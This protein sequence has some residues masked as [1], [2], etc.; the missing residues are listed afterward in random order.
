MSVLLAHLTSVRIRSTM[1][2][3]FDNAVGVDVGGTFTDFLFLIDEEYIVQKIP[4]TPDDPSIGILQGLANIKTDL[5]R[6]AH[7]STIATNALLEKAGARTA[8]VVTEGFKDI[9]EIGRQAR[10]NIYELEPTPANLLIPPELIIEFSGKLTPDGE[11]KTNVSPDLYRTIIENAVSNNVEALA[12]CLLFSH[13][14]TLFEDK[15][16][17]VYENIKHDFKGHKLPY[18]SIS[19]EVSPEYREVE[20]ASTTAL[21]A[22]VGPIMST[23]LSNLEKSLQQVDSFV[24]APSLHII[25]SD[26]GAATTSQVEKLPVS[27]LLSGPSAGVNGALSLARAVDEHKI[28]TLDIGGTSTDIALCDKELPYRTNLVIQGIPARTPVVDIHTVGAGGGSVAYLDT[29][30]ALR[31]GPRSVGSLPGPACYGKSRELSSPAFSVTDAHAL[32]GRLNRDYFLADSLQID[33]TEAERAAEPFLNIFSNKFEFAQAVIDVTN[34]N[35]ERAVRVVS[36]QKGFNP[37]EFT[38]MPFGG[39]GPLHACDVAEMLNIDKILIPPSPGVLAALGA[40]Q[41]GHTL[42]MGQSVLQTM[43]EDSVESV[44]TNLQQAIKI[45]SEKLSGDD[46]QYRAVLDLRFVGQ[47]HEI[48][49]NIDNANEANLEVLL[50]A[51]EE[52]VE[53]HGHLYGHSG[54]DVEIANIRVTGFVDPKFT[55][56]KPVFPNRR[57]N[58]TGPLINQ[59]CEAIFRGESQRTPIYLRTELSADDHIIG[60]ALVTQLDTT[61][62]ITPAWLGRVDIEGNLILSKK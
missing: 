43:N 35:I 25:Q 54:Y 38:L 51:K 44:L 3:K 5:S 48:G 56:P 55:P 18:L 58:Q 28:I 4:T 59:Y 12:I 2:S 57:N 42:T 23:Y 39:A 9:L 62:L 60:P 8:L 26:G 17:E 22:Y 20:R 49:V 16:R 31:V 1:T 37:N 19:S 6:V 53:R 14:N 29:G 52:F 10:N 7:G 36:V 30:G 33:V 13:K 21:N 45:I 27:T 34:A 15:F 24:V 50:D 47:S 46:I 61:T 32:L 40:L 41:A 11:I